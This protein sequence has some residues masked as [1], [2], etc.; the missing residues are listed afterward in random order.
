LV[1]TN[2]NDR[3]AGSLHSAITSANAA[4][5]DDM[6]TFSVDGTITLASA[7]PDLA[8]SGTLTIT[9]NGVANTLISGNNSVRVFTVASGAN[10]TLNTLTLTDGSADDGKDDINSANDSGGGILNIGST[11]TLTNS[12]VSI[13]D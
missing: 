4:A 13:I 1:V 10:V 6:I 9:G 7:L 3:G 11:V 8:N 2:L 5:S 12:I